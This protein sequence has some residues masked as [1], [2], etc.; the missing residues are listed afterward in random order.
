LS[1]GQ[2]QRIEIARVLLRSRQ[3][4]LLDEI[5]SALDKETAGEIKDFIFSLENVTIVEI[6][7]HVDEN[8]YELYDNV[9]VLQPS[10]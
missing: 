10:S 7:H 8:Q 6:A 4:L 2:K 9:V 3:V 1:G 5:T